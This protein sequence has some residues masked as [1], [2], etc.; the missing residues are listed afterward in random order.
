MSRKAGRAVALFIIVKKPR[1]L[2]EKSRMLLWLE[3]DC[4]CARATMPLANAQVSPNI[5]RLLGYGQNI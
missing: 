4:M 3:V 5:L 1:N 2:A